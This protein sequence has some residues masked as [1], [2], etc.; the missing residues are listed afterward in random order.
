MKSKL[1]LSIITLLAVMVPKGV[2]ADAT[3]QTFGSASTK[4]WTVTSSMKDIA[5]TS[6]VTLDGIVM[7]FGNATGVAYQWDYNEKNKGLLCSKTPSNDGTNHISS[8]STSDAIPS[9]GCV[10]KFAPSADGVLTVTWLEADGNVFFVEDNSGTKTALGNYRG[11]TGSEQV[12]QAKLYSGRTYYLFQLG[13]SLNAGRCTL[14]GVSYA[15][16]SDI[17]VKTISGYHNWN[18]IEEAGTWKKRIEGSYN[19]LA[20]LGSVSWDATYYRYY[21]GS[22]ASMQFYV[23]EN[24]YLV[25]NGKL[26]DGIKLTFNAT[27]STILKSSYGRVYSKYYGADTKKIVKLENVS[28]KT[29]ANIFSIAWIPASSDQATRTLSVTLDSKGYATYYPCF[30]VNIPTAGEGETQLKAY[31]LSAVNAASGTITPNEITGTI[32][33]N[34]AVILVGKGGQTYNFTKYDGE[35][36]AYHINSAAGGAGVNVLRSAYKSGMTLAG[37]TGT[38]DYYAYKK[39][40]G[41]FAKVTADL[42]I[43]EGL[44]YFTTAKSAGAREFRLEFGDET[45]GVNNVRSKQ[46]EEKREYFNLSGQRVSQPSKGLYIVN[47]KKVMFN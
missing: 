29:G 19:D 25:V 4:S 20:I 13:S 32:P 8:W 16:T 41:C 11:T 18:F 14:R 35:K 15:K 46:A 21:L 2:W 28:V 44:C 1:L 39:N 7:T 17:E 9:Y 37:S 33:A 36:N 26:S 43:P 6:T 12:Y 42:T 45:T 22:D 34:T 5:P 38:V 3:V 23:Q 24:G 27:E 31:Y 40:S 47:G 10:F 30:S